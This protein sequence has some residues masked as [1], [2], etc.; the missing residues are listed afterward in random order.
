MTVPPQLNDTIVALNK[1]VMLLNEHMRGL[2]RK[3][4][5]LDTTFRSSLFQ[6][7][8]SKGKP[9]AHLVRAIARVR[10]ALSLS[11]F[12]HV[13]RQRMFFSADNCTGKDAIGTAQR[14][15]SVLTV[16]NCAL[17]VPHSPRQQ[18]HRRR[19]ASPTLRHHRRG[20]RW[21]S[22]N[23]TAPDSKCRRHSRAQ[24][25]R[26]AMRMCPGRAYSASKLATLTSRASRPNTAFGT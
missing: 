18:Q 4:P 24:T 16:T 20:P 25:V 9:L 12:T 23:P 19:A 21:L 13:C 6:Y 2:E 22:R 17:Q 14:A 1:S 3:L 8:S 10:G 5:L 11:S 7:E 15:R 26:E